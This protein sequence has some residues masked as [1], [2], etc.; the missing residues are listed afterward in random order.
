[1]I[2]GIEEQN[3]ERIDFIDR[4]HE[5]IFVEDGLDGARFGGEIVEEILGL[6]VRVLDL[7]SVRM[8]QYSTILLKIPSCRYS[9]SL[10][11]RLAT[12]TAVM[13]LGQLIVM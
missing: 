8:C 13:S 12:L 6:G 4:V 11:A 5:L 7:F 3:L 2:N 10:P 1:M 9:A